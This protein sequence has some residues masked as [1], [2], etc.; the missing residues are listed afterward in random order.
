M[1]KVPFVQKLYENK[2][3]YRYC[4]DQI[5]SI[6]HRMQKR[7]TCHDNQSGAYNLQGKGKRITET[8]YPFILQ[9][10]DFSYRYIPKDF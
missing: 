9:K 3:L 7:N 1:D 6:L 5:S 4:Y 10:S 2:N 8:G